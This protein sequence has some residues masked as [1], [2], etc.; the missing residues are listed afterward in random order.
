MSQLKPI[1]PLCANPEASAFWHD[2]R[3]NFLRCQRCLLVFVPPE[4]HLSANEEKAEYDLHQNLPDDEGYR[5]FLGRLAAPLLERLSP[6]SV[7]LDFGCGPGPTLSLMFNEIGHRM[8]DYDPF[9]APDPHVFDQQ[10]DFITATEVV[11][12]LHSPGRELVRL[13]SC[14]SEG[15]WLGI[16][17]K[18]V[19][20]RGA[21]SAWH[22]KNDL[23]HICFFCRQTFQWWAEKHGAALTFVGNDVILLRK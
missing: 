15:G 2:K 12:H 11:E 23:T 9:Y 4:Q 3:R 13:W 10:Y 6:G 18:M 1:C 7:G 5:S 21:F 17:T 16:M 14:L 19:I 22:Y 20:D 8:K